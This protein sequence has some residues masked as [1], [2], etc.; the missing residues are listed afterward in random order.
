M[1]GAVTEARDSQTGEIERTIDFE[2][3]KVS[4]GEFVEKEGDRFGLT[5]SGKFDET[6]NFFMEAAK[7]QFCTV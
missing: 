4:L 2:K 1:S 5:W 7:V 6:G 3:L